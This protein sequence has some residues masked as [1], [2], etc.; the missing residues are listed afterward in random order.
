MSL[1]FSVVIPTFNRK[2]SLVR[3]LQSLSSQTIP[4]DEFEVIVVDDGS[5]DGTNTTIESHGWPFAMTVLREQNS[6]PSAARNLGVGKARGEVIAFTEDDVEVRPDWLKSAAPYFADAR[7]VLV[8]G[9]TVYSHTDVG[10]RRFEAGE[11]HS[12]IPCNL[13]VRKETF[14]A[15]G[16]YDPAFY[17]AKTGLYF[18]EDADLGFRIMETGA[19]TRLAPDVVVEHPRQFGTLAAC[20]R[21]V[22]RYMFDPLLYRKHPLRFRQMIEVKNVLGFRIHRPQHYLALAY[23]VLAMALIAG[24]IT[25]SDSISLLLF[26]AVFVS[27]MLFRYK[28]QGRG[29]L[30]LYR[31]GETLAFFV[32]PLVYV[33]SFLKGCVR[34]KS[35]GLVL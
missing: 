13:F 24:L 28:Y 10:V 14:T 16:G 25:G 35:F 32:L 26:G 8:E 17:E 34:F 33:G 11:R 30:R 18:R 7:V 27:S 22:R 2:E 6:G 3:C 19:A 20:F 12:F 1:R 4:P 21:H 31:L 5:T 23:V 15:L 9:R 29:A